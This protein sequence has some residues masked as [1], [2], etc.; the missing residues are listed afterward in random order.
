MKMNKISGY[1]SSVEY[2]SDIAELGSILYSSNNSGDIRN[3]QEKFAQI[4]EKENT[5]DIFL[6]FRYVR[7]QLELSFESALCLAAGVFTYNAKDVQLTIEK[8]HSICLCFANK[9]NIGEIFVKLGHGLYLNPTIVDFMHGDKPSINKKFSIYNV[10]EDTSFHNYQMIN[11]L[12]AFLHSYIKDDKAKPLAVLLD[13]NNGD[14]RRFVLAK[15]AEK[16]DC[17]MLT[18]NPDDIDEQDLR[19]VT[20]LARLYGAIVCLEFGK[21]VDVRLVEA[22]T[23]ELGLVFVVADN[24][25][26]ERLLEFTDCALFHKSLEA[27]S[28][29]EREAIVSSFF[30]DLLSY[31]NKV[32]LSGEKYKHLNCG[33]YKKLAEMLRLELLYKGNNGNEEAVLKSCIDKMC[34]DK[35]FFGASHMECKY[36]SDDLILPPKQKNQF[37]EICDFIKLKDTVYRTWGFESKVQYGK[38]MSVLFY[39]APGTGKTMAATVMAN[40]VGLELYRVDLSQLI[41][42]YI[43]ETQKNIGGVFDAA[44]DKNCILFFDEADALFTRRSEGSDSQDRHSNAEIAYLLQ[45]TEQHDGVCVL[46]TNLLQNFDEAFRRRIT[47]MIHLPLP[48]AE[49]RKQ[50][51]KNIFPENAPVEDIDIDFLGE[52]LTLSGAE[53][54]NAAI[55]A[56][57]LSAQSS[58]DINMSNLLKGAKLEYEK[59]GKAFEPRLSHL[60]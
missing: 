27:L 14:G 2:L 5:S 53:I 18:L 19:D 28:R 21:T 49:M 24:V 13:G 48:D 51:W 50:I 31:E 22:M 52:N 32:E 3:A 44:K 35:S 4:E 60:I 42:K 58:E 23:N 41:S 57:F 40:E 6:P 25:G 33:A 11:N 39:G 1:Q 17:I 8:M 43:G 20:L 56:A 45:R 26:Q 38:G 59:Q 9:P 37:L 46:A 7:E 30:A 29:Q 12:A 55:H 10:K 34:G 47:Y 54:K 15:M 16:I 36:C